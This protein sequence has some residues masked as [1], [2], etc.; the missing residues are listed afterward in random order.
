MAIP[1]NLSS[2]QEESAAAD[3]NEVSASQAPARPQSLTLEVAPPP[4]DVLENPLALI[5]VPDYSPPRESLKDGLVRLA[6]RFGWGGPMET[7]RRV[8][9]IQVALAVTMASVSSSA[10]RDVE[11]SGLLKRYRDVGRFKVTQV[12]HPYDLME[13]FRLVSRLPESLPPEAKKERRRL[14]LLLGLILRQ[15]RTEI[16][17]TSRGPFTFDTE[18]RD[19]FI[20]S[21]QIE[22]KVSFTTYADERLSLVQM[23][24]DNCHHGR[25]YYL[26]SL[27][28]RE[29]AANEGRM[30]VMYC[31][32]LL[33]LARM[34]WDGRMRTTP[35]IRRLPPRQEVLFMVRR[36][37]SLKQRCLQDREY[38]ERVK[39]M[40]S[41]FQDRPFTW[42]PGG[43]GDGKLEKGRG[44]KKGA[45]SG[46]E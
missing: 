1:T 27:L 3:V 34:E 40:V 9:R 44:R 6:G 28:S 32:A 14:E 17:K 11:A 12:R 21:V 43:S 24:H 33:T 38:E 10:A 13:I 36:D 15:Y 46:P 37:R 23:L 26:F 2:A 18:S 7:L 20:R 19:Y 5:D 39:T 4:E 25:Y 35:L 30:F 16:S 31:Q 29:P 8:R 45:K 41:V 42:L 22:Q